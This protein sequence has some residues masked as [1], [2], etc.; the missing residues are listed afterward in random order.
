M[1]PTDQSGKVGLRPFLRRM[2]QSVIG[3]PR[4]PTD[5]SGKVGLRLS[6]RIEVHDSPVAAAAFQLTRAVRWDC[7]VRPVA[8]RLMGSVSLPTDQSGKVGL[9]L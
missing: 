3:V 9:R 4:L 6:R 2:T 8:P 7:D 1:L 5:Q